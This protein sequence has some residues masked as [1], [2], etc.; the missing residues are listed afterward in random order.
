MQIDIPKLNEIFGCQVDICRYCGGKCDLSIKERSLGAEYPY[1]EC[2]SCKEILKGY[3]GMFFI[4][5]CDE[6]PMDRPS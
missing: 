4:W 5:R 2:P 1:A 6:P 3:Q